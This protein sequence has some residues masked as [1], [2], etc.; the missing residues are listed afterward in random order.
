M[1]PQRKANA[2]RLRSSVPGR[3]PELVRDL[4][5]RDGLAIVVGS[6]I[7]SGIYLVPGGIARQIPS[8]KLVLL[9]WLAGALLT[10]FGALSLAELGAMYPGAGGLYVYL[11]AAYGRPVA[12]LY[13]WGLLT[14]IH[15]GS[16]ATLAV[17]FGLY[18]SQLIPLSPPLQ[19]ASAIAIILLLTLVNTFGLRTGKWVQNV[20]TFKIG[21]AHV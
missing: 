3:K 8:M 1:S 17:A 18:L 13:G 12:F 10:L 19:K 7:G 11:R 6:V 15:S 20:L 5:F 9:I 2:T 16:L 21:R 14:L 4:T